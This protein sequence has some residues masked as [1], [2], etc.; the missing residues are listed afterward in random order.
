M[1]MKDFIKII[2]NWRIIAVTIL[3]MVAALLLMGDSD[4][5]EALL[6]SKAAGLGMAWAAWKLARRW[7]GK[8]PELEIFNDND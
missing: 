7:E 4:N 6:L 1:E 2:G 5:I 8:M 3:V